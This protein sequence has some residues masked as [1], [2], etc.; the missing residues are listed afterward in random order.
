MKPA[1]LL[2]VVPR[3]A[4]PGRY[5][6]FPLG[7]AY[8]VSSL[9]K[10]GHAVE[11][12]NLCHRAGPVPALIGEALQGGPFDAVCTGGMSTHW[13]L[14]EE[15]LAA[16]RQASPA[17]RTVVGGPI[18]TAQPD[19][20]FANLP[21]DVGVIG[22]GE[23][24]AV[25]LAGA[26]AGGGDLSQVDGLLFRDGAGNA[27][28]TPPRKPILELDT[29][30]FPDYQAFGLSAWC[31]NEWQTVSPDLQGVY[32]DAGEDVRLAEILCSRSCPF[33]C[34]FCYHPL[35]RRYRQR[36]LDD[37]FAEID[38]LV[39]QYGIRVLRIQDELFSLDNERVREFCARIKPYGIRWL[40]QWRV[41]HVDRDILR[42]LRDANALFIGF[43]IE[44]MS[45]RVLT[46]MKKKTRAAQNQAALEMAR[47]EGVMAGGNIIIGDPAETEEAFGE[48]YSWW[49][50]NPQFNVAMYHILAVPDS[51]LYREAVKRGLIGDELAFVK[52]RFPV[53]NLTRLG[54]RRFNRIRR[55]VVFQ[56]VLNRRTLTGEVTGSRR[57][58]RPDED[59]TMRAF[60]V[61]CPHC[62]AS[63]DYR[64]PLFTRSL[65]VTLVCR[66]CFAR[67][68]AR[69]GAI[70]RGDYLPFAGYL[71]I[72]L[73]LAYKGLQGNALFMAAVR[74]Y[75]KWRRR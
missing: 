9:K 61:R 13:S 28:R 46:S 53:I 56:T 39:K 74:R 34:T 54:D 55:K 62:R 44:S 29:L 65:Y 50:A 1:R 71:E 15:V 30:P 19:L 40:A 10:A 11:V 27:V 21:I 2:V 41:E 68:K 72:W 63:S 5:Y 8:I 7:L 12:L 3:F 49:L 6:P 43:G 4:S 37:I 67:M 32:F 14:I 31:A 60:T 23:E 51:P 16:V 52:K 48:S 20:A 38:L 75:L 59:R 25:E 45:D 47:E 69:T 64:F 66:R 24:T 35:G 33:E 26:L 36:S 73:A 70:F 22:E 58:A 57:D 17:I 42:T 18:V